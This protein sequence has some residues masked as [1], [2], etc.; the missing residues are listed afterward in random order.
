MK[1]FIGFLTAIL[2]FC[3]AVTAQDQTTPEPADG[4]WEGVITYKVN[5][6]SLNQKFNFTSKMKAIYHT[7]NFQGGML[8]SSPPM[9]F[10]TRS[11]ISLRDAGAAPVA[12]LFPSDGYG[13]NDLFD[14]YYSGQDPDALSYEVKSFKFTQNA[15]GRMTSF[16]NAVVAQVPWSFG[17][18]GEVIEDV[19]ITWKWK[20]PLRWTPPTPE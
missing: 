5:H 17:V 3:G 19:S 12:D 8:L 9:F 6:L 1:K 11:W 2:V 20:S 16:T 13:P 10:Q 15:D 7:G 18:K 14:L 4:L